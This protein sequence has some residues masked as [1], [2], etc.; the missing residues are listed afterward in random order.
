MLGGPRLGGRR[1]LAGGAGSLSGEMKASAITVCGTRKAGASLA[2]KAALAE[3][4]PKHTGHGLVVR[5]WSFPG[6]PCAFPS[7]SAS[8]ST[9]QMIPAS[10]ACSN[11]AWVEKAWYWITLWRARVTACSRM[12]ATAIQLIYRLK[13]IPTPQLVLGYSASGAIAT[14]VPRQAASYL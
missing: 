6:S 14:S 13:R 2:G 9:W 7:S 3:A 1:N 12:P 4:K 5:P 8:L 11:A 10:K